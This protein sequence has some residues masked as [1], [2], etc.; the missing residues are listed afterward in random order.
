MFLSGFDRLVVHSTGISAAMEQW[1]DY[2]LDQ[3]RG[4]DIRHAALVLIL[5]EVIYCLLVMHPLHS[6][7]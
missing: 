4:F 7:N 5:S 6:Q 3:E 1:N 2:L